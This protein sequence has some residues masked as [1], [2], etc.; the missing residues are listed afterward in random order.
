MN[1]PIPHMMNVDGSM[2]VTICHAQIPPKVGGASW[3]CACTWLKMMRMRHWV[4]KMCHFLLLT[5]VYKVHGTLIFPPHLRNFNFS[6]N[7]NI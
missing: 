4:E 7:L 1:R 5:A 3:G 2:L 6:P